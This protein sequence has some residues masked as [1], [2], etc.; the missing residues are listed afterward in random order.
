MSVFVDA[1]YSSLN[2][3]REELC[4]D[5][6][7]IIRN[8]DSVI[9]VLADGLGSGVRAN[10]L[11]T[12]TSK[13]IGTMLSLGSTIDEAV[14]TIVST[15]PVSKDK[16][17]AY[18][19]FTILQIFESGDSYLVEFDNPC[20]IR[21]VKGKYSSL[22]KL[23]RVIDGKV[24]HE[25]RFKANADDILILL[26]DGAVNAGVGHSLK[27]GWQWENI[28]NYAERIYWKNMHSNA[29]SKLILSVCSSLYEGDPGD[30]TTVVTVKIKKQVNVNIIIGPPVD[31]NMDNYVVNK[32]INSEG[33][34]VVCG[35][36]TSQIV[37]RES[38]RKMSINLNYVDQNMPPTAEI[39]GIDLAT[40]GILTMSR[41]L[42][43]ARKYSTSQNTVYDFMNINSQDGASRLAKMLLE[44]STSVHFFVGR[45]INPAH[46]NPDFPLYFG[47]KLNLVSEMIKCLESIGKKVYAEYF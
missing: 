6:V 31:R 37:A 15:L 10:I 47:V 42:E 27:L 34:K 8:K 18:S 45:A 4:G 22:E 3:S 46:Q 11:A 28:R 36:T 14:E 41:A 12:L 16:G 19:T 35:G 29:I 32:F 43:Y 1:S 21:L 44:D 30:D 9:I 2:K 24:I 25:C 7:E 20:V 40:E 17:L 39:E 26:S 38:G 5:K 13:I 33:K 23:E